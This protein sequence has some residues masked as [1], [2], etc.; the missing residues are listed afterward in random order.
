MI[1]ASRVERFELM[2]QT[3]HTLLQSIGGVTRNEAFD[4]INTVIDS[5]G[6]DHINQ[7]Y[8]MTLALLRDS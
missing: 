1:L 4:A 2:R 8:E 3:Y 5:V 6:K 7:I